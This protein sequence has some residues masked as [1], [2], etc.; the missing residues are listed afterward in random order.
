[1][2]MKTIWKTSTSHHQATHWSS[3][4]N[5]ALFSRRSGGSLWYSAQKF[6]NKSQNI[7]FDVQLGDIYFYYYYL[8][9]WNKYFVDLEKE[10]KKL[11][12]GF[13]VLK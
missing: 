9:P 6:K 8:M 13:C 3:A 10:K 11:K 12:Y 1:M 7:I 2:E 4:K 5:K